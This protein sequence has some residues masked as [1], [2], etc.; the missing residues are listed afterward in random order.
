MMKVALAPQYRSWMLAL[1]PATLGVGTAALWFRS[2][3]WPLSVDA[4]G[5]KLRSRRR[6]GWSSINKISVS[7]SYLEGHVSQM[8]IHHTHGVDKVP[9]GVLADGQE[10][11]KAILDTFE[12]AKG[13]KDADGRSLGELG[14]NTR[15]GA[16]GG[17]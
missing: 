9:V 6:V 14:C 12:H 3:N 11:V 10:V 5:V 2:R 8:R 4:A 17:H 16:T 1:L 13:T 7:C 15:L